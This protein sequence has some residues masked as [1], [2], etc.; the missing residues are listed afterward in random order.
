MVVDEG[1]DVVYMEFSNVFDKVPSGRPIQKIK[2]HVIDSN[3]VI[4]I[5][6]W[7]TDRR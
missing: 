1:R 5:Q 2:M 7:F 3:L 4:S 6:N